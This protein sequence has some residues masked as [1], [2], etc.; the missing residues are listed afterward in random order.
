MA[1]S[2]HAGTFFVSGQRLFFDRAFTTV[3]D[4]GFVANR[5]SC[6]I[7]SACDCC[8]YSCDHCRQCH[9]KD[10][11]SYFYIN[12]LIH[13]ASAIMA[14]CFLCEYYYEFQQLNYFHK[15]VFIKSFHLYFS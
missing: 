7:S 8:C 10:L 2:N 12:L 4:W 3:K 11:D 14:E 13:G 15:Q 6:L 9:L 5:C 1:G